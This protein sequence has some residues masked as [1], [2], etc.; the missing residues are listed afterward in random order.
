MY[1]PIKL[2]LIQ[3]KENIKQFSL[4]HPDTLGSF[5]SR[6][7]KQFSIY[8]P[9]EEFCL[10]NMSNGSIIRTV[11]FE[12]GVIYKLASF[13]EQFIQL[14]MQDVPHQG[15]KE[16]PVLD[17]PQDLDDGNSQPKE[18]I[19]EEKKEDIKDEFM[20]T[21][22]DIDLT[23]IQDTYTLS[24]EDKKKSINLWANSQ[25][26]NLRIASGRRNLKDGRKCFLECS[27][28]GCRFGLYFQE[29][30]TNTWTFIRDKSISIHNHLLTYEPKSEFNDK[31]NEHIMNFMNKI[32]NEMLINFINLLCGTKLTPKQVENKVTQLKW[33]SWIGSMT[34]NLL[35]RKK[36]R[37]NSSR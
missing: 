36:S 21:I 10:V 8:S 19:K 22:V 29:K 32:P 14:S 20:A 13:E 11:S 3:Y 7:L 25:G 17:L 16:V 37:I 5:I 30:I 2:F 28:K 24:K 1:D 33:K 6:I 26:F 35:Y 15:K 12:E 9:V 27:E 18:E 4:A 34:Y 31:V 23:R